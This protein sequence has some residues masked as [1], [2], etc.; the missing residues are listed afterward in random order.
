[1]NGRTVE[2][3]NAKGR[4]STNQNGQKPKANW[5]T[6]ILTGGIVVGTVLIGVGLSE[7]RHSILD[8]RKSQFEKKLSMAEKRAKE[9][10]TKMR[11]DYRKNMGELSE[12]YMQVRLA[13]RSRDKE[14][15]AAAEERVKRIEKPCCNRCE[16]GE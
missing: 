8:I 14:K 7:I 13:L 16:A 15:I 11:D 5:G 4:V 10:R 2:K 6:R 1:M 3:P 9:K 12:A